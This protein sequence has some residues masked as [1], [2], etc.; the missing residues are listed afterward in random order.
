MRGDDTSR[1]ALCQLK[2]LK[3]LHVIGVK[4]FVN[5]DRD[6]PEFENKYYKIL[7][8]FM[9]EGIKPTLRKYYAHK[10]QQQRY[11]TFLFTLCNGKRYLNISVQSQTTPRNFILFNLFYECIEFEPVIPE[12]E[13][14]TYLEKYNQFCCDPDYIDFGLED[15]QTISYEVEQQIFPA[16]YD[17][18]LFIFGL[19][20]YVRMFLM[21][22]FRSM[23]KLACV[24]YKAEVTEAFQ[25]KYSFEHSFLVPDRAL[26]L[27]KNVE[28]PVAIIATY[29]SDHSSLANK[30]FRYN[31]Q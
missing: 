7:Y 14:E 17:R 18:G 31:P 29:H 20:G 3:N 2:D 25:K 12:K 4:Q 22:H 27:L 9:K 16:K 24:D 21:Q 28:V 13:L 19:G 26:S 6:R 15:S 23:K 5:N 1:K 30:I 11:L 10:Q 8:F